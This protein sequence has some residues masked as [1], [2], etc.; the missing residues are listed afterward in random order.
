M[1]DEA[2]ADSKFSHLLLVSTVLPYRNERMTLPP[3]WLPRVVFIRPLILI[4]YQEQKYG[5]C[6]VIKDKNIVG[7][8]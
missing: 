2:P 7:E 4:E 8:I 1:Q 5:C 3:L 6:Q